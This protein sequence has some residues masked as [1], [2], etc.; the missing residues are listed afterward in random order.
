M[1]R[2]LAIICFA[3]CSLVCNA[4]DIVLAGSYHNDSDG[5]EYDVILTYDEGKIT[6]LDIDIRGKK[7]SS[8]THCFVRGESNIKKWYE[9]LKKLGETYAKWDKLQKENKVE[10]GVAS[11]NVDWPEV[12][13]DGNVKDADES[14]TYYFDGKAHIEVFYI[15]AKG[16]YVNLYEDS[17]VTSY[18]KK[19][20]YYKS[21]N[22]YYLGKG[23]MRENLNGCLDFYSPEHF[24]AFVKIMNPEF[25]KERM[26]M[27]ERA[28]E[29]E[30]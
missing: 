29:N 28:L 10:V 18:V 8:D 30:K 14:E 9:A 16:L 2:W 26:Q 3:M 7:S 4:E 25:L 5:K 22:T 24:E 19:L 27:K 6:G 21:A 15:G 11:I 17:W 13:I 12:L 20:I 1:D 23:Q